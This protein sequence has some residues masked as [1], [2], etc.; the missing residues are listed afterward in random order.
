MANTLYNEKIEP[1]IKAF[2]LSY[3]W[4]FVGMLAYEF[5]MQDSPYYQATSIGMT[6]GMTFILPFFIPFFLLLASLIEPINLL[7]LLIYLGGLF[8][9]FKE[10]NQFGENK[11]F[12]LSFALAI[13]FGISFAVIGE[14]MGRYVA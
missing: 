8:V 7:Y 13:L 14:L 12:W 2:L 6:L 10:Q 4:L 9:L 5:S 11:V 3:I 1:F